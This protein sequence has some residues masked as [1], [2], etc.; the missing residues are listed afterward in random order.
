MP[1]LTIISELILIIK[2]K[3]KTNTAKTTVT[4]LMV[5]IHKCT[6]TRITK[7]NCTEMTGK[8][9]LIINNNSATKEN[10]L[11]KKT[12]LIN[13]KRRINPIMLNSRIK[14]IISI[15]VTK[16]KFRI[17]PLFKLKIKIYNN[18]KLLTKIRASIIKIC[19][20]TNLLLLR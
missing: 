20:I 7:V 5:I 16:I 19:A 15:A 1:A 3:E 9:I 11:N 14:I 2:L 6:I 12:F 4:K 13:K 10:I 8:K 18:V 17:N